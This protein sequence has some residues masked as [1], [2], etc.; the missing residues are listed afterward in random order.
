MEIKKQGMELKYDNILISCKYNKVCFILF[1][2][3][4]NNVNNIKTGS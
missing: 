3:N 2:N 4:I 1:Y